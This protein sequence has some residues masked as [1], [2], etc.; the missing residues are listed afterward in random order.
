MLSSPTRS[1]VSAT[2]TLILATIAAYALVMMRS[3]DPTA[4]A[5]I[6]SRYG[7]NPGDFHWWQLVT[8]LFLHGGLAHLGFNM[9]GLAV[10]GPPLEERLGRGRFILF[11]L[12]CGAAASAAHVALSK[13]PAIGASGA[14]YGLL[15]AFA[16]IYP[17]ARIGILLAPRPIPAPVLALV[18]LLIDIL[19]AGGVG[20]R[21]VANL[22]HIGGLL[23]G[24]FAATIM[25]WQGWIR[26][27]GSDILFVTRQ[28]FRRRRARRVLNAPARVAAEAPPPTDP[29][30]PRIMQ[31]RGE[32]ASLHGARNL[33]DAARRYSELLAIDPRATLPEQIHL[34]VANQLWAA[35]EARS[36]VAA[37][38]LHRM[39]YPRSARANEIDLMLALAYA[40]RL[41]ALDRAREILTTLRPR[42]AGGPLSEATEQLAAE[43][44]A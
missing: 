7:A 17:R 27:D 6:V 16:V 11:Y 1:P 4:S 31:L 35:G 32:I 25:L 40:R 3:S 26:R 34:D 9:I 19:G 14:V 21:G 5:A 24:V 8:S 41:G 20:G 22:A 30:A 43:V 29:N 36:A 18:Y 2:R 10:F 38:E 15:G 39:R 42:V 44:G 13:V 23:C 12:F 37:W 33:Q 28:W